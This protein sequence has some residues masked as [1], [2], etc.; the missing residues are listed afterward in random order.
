MK[1]RGIERTVFKSQR[2]NNIPTNPT[3]VDPPNLHPALSLVNYGI[4]E[5]GNELAIGHPLKTAPD[6][7]VIR[8][9]DETALPDVSIVQRCRVLA[10]VNPRFCAWTLSREITRSFAEVHHLPCRHA[11]TL[12]GS[13]CW[14]VVDHLFLGGNRPHGPFGLERFGRL[15][16]RRFCTIEGR[17]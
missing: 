6:A 11:E 12:D 13:Q 17:H 14:P 2:S 3:H 16:Y 8:N 4:V 10:D 15:R 7:R 5:E 1:G 9:L